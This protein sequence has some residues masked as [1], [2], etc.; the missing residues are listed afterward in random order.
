MSFEEDRE[1]LCRNLSIPLEEEY[2]LDSQITRLLESLELTVR[3]DRS[4]FNGASKAFVRNHFNNWTVSEEAKA[5]QPSATFFGNKNGSPR[6]V[7]TR[8]TFPIHVDAASLHSVVHAAPQPPQYDMEGIGYVN[9]LDCHWGDLDPEDEDESEEPVEG[10]RLYDVGWIKV[11]VE[12]L[13]PDIYKD[14]LE[15]HH[16]YNYFK[17]PPEVWV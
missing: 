1:M 14:L 2:A 12:R 8:Y 16:W 10:C 5:E 4:L 6:G 3:E 9:V 17:R 11:R 13:V 15:H 7:S